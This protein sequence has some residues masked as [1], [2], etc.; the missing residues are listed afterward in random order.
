MGV[1]LTKPAQFIS[2]FT[3]LPQQHDVL[4]GPHKALMHLSLTN[5]SKTGLKAAACT[6][7][8]EIQ[9]GPTTDPPGIKPGGA[10]DGK[11]QLSNCLNVAPDPPGIKPAARRTQ[12]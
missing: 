5:P 7:S 6:G 9:D 12:P 10:A 4:E 3:D 8:K 1:P 2:P 11:P